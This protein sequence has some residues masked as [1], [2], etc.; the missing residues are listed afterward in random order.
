[1]SHAPRSPRLSAT[2]MTE[3]VL[4]Q[5]A[6]AVGTAFGGQ[7]MAWIDICAALAAHRHCGRVA[8]TVS[9]DEL[10][11]LAPVHVGDIVSLRSRLNAVF[12]SSME[13][14]VELDVEY[15]ETGERKRCVEAFATFVCVDQGRPT[16]APPLLTENDEDR[17]RA[18]DAAQR[19]AERLKRR[20]ARP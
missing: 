20:A 5:H 8:V 16:H 11:F 3:I 7:I 15:P 6:N 12:G 4:P 1:M 2:T 9:I 13:V 17:Q 10:V 19:R 18:L 14:A